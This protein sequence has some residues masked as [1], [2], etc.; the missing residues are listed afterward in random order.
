VQRHF[1]EQIVVGEKIVDADGFETLERGFRRT[2]MMF[3]LDALQRLLQGFDQFTAR[4]FSMTV[5]P[6]SRIRSAWA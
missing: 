3:A 5:K 2:Q 4:A 1:P 6:S